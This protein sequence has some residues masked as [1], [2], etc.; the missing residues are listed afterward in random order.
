MLSRQEAL[1]RLTAPGQPF[2]LTEITA[3]GRQVRVFRHAP[4]TLRDLYATTRSE[5]PFLVYEDER[6][7]FE[8]V[9]RGSCA[10]AHALRDRLGV[11]PG[12]RIAIAMRNY[13]EWMIAFNA[14]TS[15]GAIAVCMNAL[16]QPAEMDYGLRHAGVSV[17]IADQERFERYQAITPSRRPRR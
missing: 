13:P 11:S 16:W 5:R 3:L 6:L 17:L 7:T 8:E 12:A 4:A 14:V 9:W 1:R 10:L 2:E 15:I